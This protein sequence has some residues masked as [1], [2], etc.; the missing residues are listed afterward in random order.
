MLQVRS[1]F[2]TVLLPADIEAKAEQAL[3]ARW[4]KM[5][6]SDI[7]VAPHHGSKTSS[8]EE[9]ID[10]VAPRYVLFPV[11][12]R[13]HYHHPNALVA[14]RYAQ[15]GILMQDSPASGAIEVRLRA[16]GFELEPYRA[17]HRRYWFSPDATETTR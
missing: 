1:G 8:T 14:Q 16:S 3:I 5:L 11:G 2:G 12:Y 15:H 10:A 13:N 17:R 4:G 6:R 9:F 7:L